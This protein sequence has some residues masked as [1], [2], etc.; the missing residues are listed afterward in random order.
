[1]GIRV[2]DAAGAA[3]ADVP[4]T[5]TALDGGKIEAIAARTDSLGEA[6]AR[7]TLGPRAGTQRARVQVGNPRTMPAF[8]VTAPATAE[9][10]GSV[11]VVTGGNQQGRVGSALKQPIV[12]MLTDRNGNPVPGATVGVVALAGSIPDSAPVADA[13]GRVEIAWMLG[14][15]AG[16]QSLELKPATGSA[17]RVTARAVPAEAANIAT[18]PVPA[19]APT[20]RLLAKPVVAMVTDAYGNAIS[21]VQVIFTVSG[22]ATAPVRV[23]TDSKG[24]AAT[25]WT[26]GPVIGDQTLTATVRGTTVKTTVL[27]R[28]TKGGVK[29]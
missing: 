8:T 7:W 25:R 18:A 27:V 29:K 9:T 4:V 15:K 26:L 10:A 3:A 19:S 16:P 21:N 14:S 1:V 23:M 13:K 20:S 6:W 24:Q 22:G 17:V 28:G 2:T 5:W 11:T 12:A